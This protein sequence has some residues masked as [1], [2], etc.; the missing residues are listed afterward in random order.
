[1]EACRL[2]P[3]ISCLIFPLSSAHQASLE[4]ASAELAS[5]QRS[6][7]ESR[8]AAANRE[9]RLETVLRKLSEAEDDARAQRRQ[10]EAAREVAAQLTNKVGRR[11]DSFVSTGDLYQRPF[12]WFARVFE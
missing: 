2:D 11:R 10:A 5:E 6:S 1:M 7:Q 9:E 12:F 8:A 3:S 4:T